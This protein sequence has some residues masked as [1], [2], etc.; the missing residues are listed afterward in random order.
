M[1]VNQISGFEIGPKKAGVSK[2]VTTPPL[3]DNPNRRVVNMADPK[4]AK[5][6]N[7]Q[8]ML[9]GKKQAGLVTIT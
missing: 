7:M 5:P 9:G 6:V 3:S 8:T 2:P 4:K 1:L